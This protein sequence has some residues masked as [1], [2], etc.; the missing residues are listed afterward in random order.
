MVIDYFVVTIV[1]TIVTKVHFHATTGFCSS[2][3]FVDNSGCTT[4]ASASRFV[5][6]ARGQLT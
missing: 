2:Q 5:D 3:S 6:F 1:T 4:Q